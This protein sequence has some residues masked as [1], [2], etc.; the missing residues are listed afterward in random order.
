MNPN[1]WLQPIPDLT[2]TD[3]DAASQIPALLPQAAQFALI[4]S[5]SFM[6]PEQCN[7]ID[8]AVMLCDG[9]NAIQLSQELVGTGFAAGCTDYD[10]QDGKWVAV[11][12]GRVNLMLT[13]DRAFYDGYLRAMEVIKYLHLTKK[14]DRIAVCQIVRDG[15]TAETV[16]AGR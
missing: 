5:A 10:A 16:K 3:I 15:M 14:S 1:D 13:H 11:R 9:F 8:F 2:A 12:V 4:G 6:P 7:D